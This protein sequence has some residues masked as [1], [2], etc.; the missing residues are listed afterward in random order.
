M[1]LLR[2][3]CG[4][5]VLL[6]SLHFVHGLHHFYSVDGVHGPGLWSAM[7]LAGTIDVFSFVGGILLLRSSR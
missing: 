7:F 1:R 2:I 5:A 3:F 4:M 6:T